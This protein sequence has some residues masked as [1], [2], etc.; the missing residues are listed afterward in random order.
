MVIPAGVKR[1]RSGKDLPRECADEGRPDKD[2][3]VRCQTSVTHVSLLFEVGTKHDV[4][5]IRT[6]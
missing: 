5:V 6:D 4:D 2:Y 3:S 1:N